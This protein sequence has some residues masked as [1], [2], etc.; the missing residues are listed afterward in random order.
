MRPLLK[1]LLITLPLAL[2][3]V[4]FLAF[5]VTNRPPPARIALAE[6]AYAVRVITPTARDIIPEVTGFGLVSPARKFEAIPQV[7][8]TAVYVNPDLQKGEILV[9]PVTAPP[10]LRCLAKSQVR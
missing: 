8:G 10:G 7:A 3:G 6:R 9:T 4:G 2:V 5:V 1:L